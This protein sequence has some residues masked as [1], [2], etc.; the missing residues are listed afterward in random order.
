MEKSALFQFNWRDAIRGAIYAIVSAL[1]TGII[2]ALESG[3]LPNTAQLLD[4]G[5][6]ALIAG[7]LYLAKRFVTNSDGKLLKKESKHKLVHQ[8]R[9]K[10]TNV[11]P[12]LLIAAGMLCLAGCVSQKG[13]VKYLDKHP[14]LSAQYCAEKY[15]VKDSVGAVVVDS[16]RHAE[17]IDYSFAIDSL[18]QVAQSAT[19]QRSK[20]SLLSAASHKQCKDIVSIQSGRIWDLL[21]EINRLRSAYKPCRPDTVFQTQNIYRENTAKVQV[22]ENQLRKSQKDN[23]VLQAE[24]KHLKSQLNKLTL[25]FIILASVFGLAIFLRIKRII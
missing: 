18:V 14:E 9:K 21:L 5:K 12:L 4:M 24:N 16:T 1:A 10:P 11:I 25:W 3:H 17:N 7:V 15:P 19:D 8:P 22:L 23:A 2:Q 6:V 13:A 20:D